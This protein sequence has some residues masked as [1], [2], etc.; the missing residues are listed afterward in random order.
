MRMKTLIGIRHQFA[1]LLILGVVSVSVQAQDNALAEAESLIRNGDFKAAYQLLEPLESAHAGQVDYDYLFGVAAVESGNASRGVFAL[2]RVL[3]ASPEHKDARAEMAK[4]HFML[5]ERDASKAE[6]NNVL[7]QNP[8]DATK[9]TIQ[10]LLTEIQK[11][12][13]TTT[14]FGAFLEFGIGVDSNVNSAAS[15]DSVS[16][17]ALGGLLI[18]LDKGAKERSDNFTQFA[19][20]LSFRHPFNGQV[21]IFGAASA[22][23]RVNSSETEFDTESL[24][25]NAGIEIKPNADNQVLLTVQDNHFDLGGDSFRRASGVTGQWLHQV[26]PR[27]QIGV[28]AQYSGL[29]YTGNSVRNADRKIIGVNAGH[30][31][32]AESK[33]IAFASLYGGREDARN[34]AF[35]F[36]SQDVVG[37]RFGGQMRLA[38]A[39]QGYTTLGYELR[40]YDARDPAFLTIRRDHQYDAAI[41]LKYIP[42]RDWAIRSQLSYTKNDSNIQLND[43]DRTVFSVVARKD[44]FW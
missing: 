4:A 14:T 39:W 21:A 43:F 6:F 32:E 1:T 27:N 28:F 7:Q 17:P 20:G 15:L 37:L 12:E 5:G 10:K 31:F 34:D 36:L 18:P 35:D 26:D 22:N 29:K 41:G 40:D 24:D 33:P 44:F 2:E 42:A 3:A 11:M 8:D 23:N 38:D 19:G 9:R 16:V 13:G 25:F 30:A